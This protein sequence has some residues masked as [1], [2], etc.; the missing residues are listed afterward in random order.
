MNIVFKW[1]LIIF[2]I[3]VILLLVIYFLSL[4]KFEQKKVIKFQGPP[5]GS[6]PYV[7]GPKAPPPYFYSEN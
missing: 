7:K 6:L 3:L 4:K 2:L 5:P 1:V